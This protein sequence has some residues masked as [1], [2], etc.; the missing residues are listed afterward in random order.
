MTDEKTG[1]LSD[2]TKIYFDETGNPS[3]A[4]FEIGLPIVTKYHEKYYFKWAELDV[5]ITVERLTENYESMAT[6][7]AH[8]TIIHA[9]KVNWLATRTKADIARTLAKFYP[10][11]WD[12]L[13]TQVTLELV[14]QLQDC[15]S[16]E[17]INQEPQSM[18][19]EYVV[20]PILPRGHPG[21]IFTKGG[22]CKSITADYFSVLLQFGVAAGNGLPFIP[23]GQQNVLYCDWE[24]DAE[25]HRRYITAI[26]KGLGID[27]NNEIAYRR[28]ENSIFNVA[29]S[30]RSDIERKDIGLVIIDSQ[31]AA[32]ATDRPGASDAQISAEYYNVLRSFN[33]TSLTIDHITK[34]SMT[35]ENGAE[36]P[37]GSVVKYNR[38]RSQFELRS[39]DESDDS[40]YKELALVHRKFNLGR[41]QKPIGIAINFNN[42]GDT[43]VDIT[44]RH[45]ELEDSEGLSKVVPRKTRLI[46]VLKRMGKATIQD[47]ANEIGEPDNT[48]KIGVQLANDKKTFVK[49]SE[50][51]YGLLAK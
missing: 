21:T 29:D 44:F 8:G 43:L 51:T 9:C 6:F 13:L 1:T 30:I 48:K 28:I 12:S 26:K 17:N 7:R 34:Q 42:D 41:K 37:Y 4:P 18:K 24:S 5:W 47:L 50:G 14:K 46:N 22:K 3:L 49:L 23:S 2:G 19:L 45:C 11:A 16:L 32:T 10:I 20:Y 31:M 36:A 38:S 25:T 27:N 35:L 40:D 33:T 15:G 39:S